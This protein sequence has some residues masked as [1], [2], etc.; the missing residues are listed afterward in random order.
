MLWICRGCRRLRI[1]WLPARHENDR[2]QQL[3]S[4][5]IRATAAATKDLPW[6]AEVVS[7][8]QVTLSKLARSVSR[9]NSGLAS[10][11]GQAARFAPL[12]SAGKTTRQWAVTPSR[13]G[14]GFPQSTDW[15]EM[16]VSCEVYRVHDCMQLAAPKAGGYDWWVTSFGENRDLY[17]RQR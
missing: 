3:T 6:I 8:V 16:G 12:P 15:P 5:E 17:L 4:A 9:M 2:D 7:G 13:D 14:R 10:D 1:V 11:S